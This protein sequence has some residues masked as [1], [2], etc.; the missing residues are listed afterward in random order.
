MSIEADDDS[1]RA[2]RSRWVVLA[3]LPGIVADLMFGGWVMSNSSKSDAI[4]ALATGLLYGGVLL[5][6]ATPFYLADLGRRYVRA[7]HGGYQSA[8]PFVLI[9]CA[10]NFVLWV[11]GI[12]MVLS[13]FGYR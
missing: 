4:A 1:A 11:G 8:M 3:L 5:A 9:Y 2:N 7:V 6:F 12:L 10:A 13:N